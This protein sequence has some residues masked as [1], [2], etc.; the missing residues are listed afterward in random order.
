MA[1][2]WRISLALDY[3]TMRPM[4]RGDMSRDTLRAVTEN[5]SDGKNNAGRDEG[6]NSCCDVGIQPIMCLSVWS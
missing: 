5:D 4:T 6:N 3:I 2:H 1:P